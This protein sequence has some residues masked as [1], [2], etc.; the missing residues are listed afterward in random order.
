MSFSSEIKE[1]LC[2]APY[3][4]SHCAY[5]EAAGK[6]AMLIEDDGESGAFWTRMG[7][8]DIEGAPCCK[9]AFLRG[10][11]LK[12]GSVSDPEKS[13]HLEFS[14]RHRKEAEYVAEYLRE[15]DIRSGITERKGRFV[16]YVKDCD[17]IAA[18]LGMMGASADALRLFGLQAER[19]VRNDVNRRSNFENANLKKSVDAAAKYRRAVKAI[20]AAGKWDSLPDSLREIG[21][22]RIE[23]TGASLKELGE[24]LDPPIGKSGVNHRLQ[25][26][27]EAAEEL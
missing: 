19:S 2:A 25:R 3:E 13:W 1:K 20:K 21:E 4:C 12:S 24:M 7:Y 6:L 26:L 14:A 23:H 18:A 16:V 10:A 27:L 9:R 8:D 17:S 22:L 11:F 15:N 5:A